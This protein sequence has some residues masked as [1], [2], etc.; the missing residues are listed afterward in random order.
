MSFTNILLCLERGALFISKA[1][2][3]RESST[4]QAHALHEEYLVYSLYIAKSRH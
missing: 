3:Q 1:K 4:H 2:A